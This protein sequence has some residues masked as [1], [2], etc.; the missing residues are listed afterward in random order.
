[1]KFA[2]RLAERF[3]RYPF[4]S[5]VLITLASLVV[6][7]ALW[8]ACGIGPRARPAP[9]PQPRTELRGYNGAVFALAFD[10]SGTW[11]AAG[12]AD[13]VARIWDP[14][15]GEVIQEMKGHHGSVTCVAVSPDGSLLA[16]G[17]AD[18]SV[19]LWEFSSGKELRTL[20]GHTE[21]VASIAFRPDGRWLAS[22]GGDKAIRLWNVSTGEELRTLEG[23]TGK[24][25]AIA[26]S[27]DGHWLASA[28]DDKTVRLWEAETGKPA[29]TLVGH[30]SRVL[31]VAFSHDGKLLASG[32]AAQT[33]TNRARRTAQLRLWNPSTGKELHAFQQVEGDVRSLAFSPDDKVLSSADKTNGYTRI[34][35]W[36]VQSRTVWDARFGQRFNIYA[37]VYSPAGGRLASAG[38][39][40]AIRLWP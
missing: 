32:G 31:S 18:K 35:S 12:T 34:I 3:R 22:V 8:S 36:D 21:G 28:S 29:S 20:T 26:F 7:V 1:M 37:L 17:S 9:P 33:E 11:L 24:V 25:N 14:S 40:G 4:W 13:H 19:K 6:L 27:P 23:H 15:K 10:P 5:Q 39:D 38:D 16:T 2:P 30:K